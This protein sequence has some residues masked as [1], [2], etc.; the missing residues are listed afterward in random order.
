LADPSNAPAFANASAEWSSLRG[1]REDSLG[2]LAG[3]LCAARPAIAI[4]I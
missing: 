3:E 1:L 4:G 2:D